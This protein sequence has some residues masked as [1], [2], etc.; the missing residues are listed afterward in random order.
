MTWAVWLNETDVSTLGYY[1]EQVGGWLHGPS[2]QYPQM[3]LPGRMGNVL[4]SDPSATARQVRLV[5]TIRTAAN[6]V[7]ARMD[8]EKQLK[9]LAYRGLVRLTVDDDVNAPLCIDGVCEAGAIEPKGGHPTTMPATGVEL[10]F[11]CPDPT[12][13]DVQASIAW[14][15]TSATAIPLGNAPASDSIV[16]IAAPVWSANVENPTITYSNAGGTTLGTMLFNGLTLTAGQDF[17]EVDLDRATATLSDAGVRSNAISLL[18]SGNFFALDP[19]D[20]D[21][22]QSAWPRLKVTATAGTPSTTITYRKRWL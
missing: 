2:R 5:G 12:W 4:A 17:L 6:T 11:T 15:G 19:M 10:Q 18:T 7:A 13:Y 1:V 9:A 16:R 14:A 20:G 3:A 21:Y 22:V 8:A